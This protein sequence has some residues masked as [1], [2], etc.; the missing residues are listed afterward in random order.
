[1]AAIPSSPSLRNSDQAVL[2]EVRLHVTAD[3]LFDQFQKLLLF[4]GQRVIHDH[5]R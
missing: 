4:F 2:L 5:L 1:M 3:E